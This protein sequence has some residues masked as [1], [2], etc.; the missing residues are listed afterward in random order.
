MPSSTT[1]TPA[2]VDVEEREGKA[3]AERIQKKASAKERFQ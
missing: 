3:K 1:V 2:S